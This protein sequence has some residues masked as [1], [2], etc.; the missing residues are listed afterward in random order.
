MLKE[1]EAAPEF[2]LPDS[3]MEMVSLSSFTGS[4][5]VVLYFYPK[6]DT[7]GC[8][9]EAIDFSELDDAF[10]SLQTV[11]LGVSR[12]DCMSHGS[13]RDK[14]GLSAY[15]CS[16]IPRATCRKYDVLQEKEVNGKKR[17]GVL[18]PH[19]SSIAE[20]SCACPI[21]RQSSRPRTGS[22]QA[23]EG[24]RVVR[25]AR[26]TVVSLTYEL[27]SVDDAV[28]EKTAEPIS[29]LHGGYEGIFPRVEQALDGK[30]AGFACRVRLEPDEAF[31]RHDAA[32][33]RIEP[34]NQF[35]P[36]VKVGMQFEGGD[37]QAV[38]S[39][40]YRYQQRQGDR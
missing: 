12:D 27:F 20:G 39:L 10:S 19:S 6:D 3:D 26:D 18:R 40:R 17:T 33:V 8:T 35:P 9:L 22:A 38:A 23:G 2:D 13:F 31:G 16:P 24:N 14:H 28:I 21:W 34:R 15:S 32:L 25:I 37:I 11:V 29:Y 4:K 5:N 30:E 36:N 7:P 1:G